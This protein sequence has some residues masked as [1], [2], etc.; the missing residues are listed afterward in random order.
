MQEILNFAQTESLDWRDFIEGE[1]N[2]AVIRFLAKWPDWPTNG[3]IIYGESGT[4][5]THISGLWARTTNAVS[6]LP[7]SLRHDPRKLF[8]M[9]CNFIF[10]NIDDFL[11]TQR[12]DWMFHFFNIAAEKKRYYLLIS[13]HHPS[14]WP[15]TLGDL[16]SRLFTL[17]VLR[18]QNPGEELMIKIAGKLSRDLGIL[19][20]NNVL[21]YLLNTVDR[22][23]ASLAKILQI[24]NALSLQEKK[25]ITLPFLRNYFRNEHNC[26]DII[27]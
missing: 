4:G 23:A 22:S 13:R 16:R 17:P 12:Q 14:V 24:L 21:E 27:K 2:V 9:E 25:P 18:M 26:R 15:V 1:E 5:K 8:S 3:L 20:H 10:D 6:V 7:E 11:D 19:I